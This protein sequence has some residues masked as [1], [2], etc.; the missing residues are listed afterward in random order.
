MLDE[1]RLA[2]H[3]VMLENSLDVGHD[4]TCHQETREMRAADEFGITRKLPR[5]AQRVP[6][7]DLL[8]RLGDPFCA[9]IAAATHLLQALDQC[10]VTVIEAE[11]DDVNGFSRE[12]HRD[13][14]T[15]DEAQPQFPRHTG[16]LVESAELVV[17]GQREQFDTVGCRAAHDRLG[18]EPAIGHRGM[19]MQVCVH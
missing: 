3:E 16:R 9:G 4:T 12:R 17:I 14:D 2:A 10:R 19:A 6:N 11:A 8:E 1:T 13:L 5:P 18:F 15:I 7:T